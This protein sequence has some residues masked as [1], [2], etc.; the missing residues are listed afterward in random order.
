[1]IKVE[2]LIKL[3][4]W[5]CMNNGRHNEKENPIKLIDKWF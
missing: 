4:S 2:A 5:T 1:M 3:T